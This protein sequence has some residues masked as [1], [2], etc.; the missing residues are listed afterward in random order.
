MSLGQFEGNIMVEE[1]KKI[2]W[3]LSF[4]LFFYAVTTK[5]QT[6]RRNTR[7]IQQKLLFDSRLD[8]R[9][10]LTI[11]ARGSGLEVRV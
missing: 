7:K 5:S 10:V 9:K 4:H 2:D 3:L 6:E 1:K 11:E 8:P